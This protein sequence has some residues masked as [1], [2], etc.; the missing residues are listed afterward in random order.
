MFFSLSISYLLIWQINCLNS[1]QMATENSDKCSSS[2]FFISQVERLKAENPNIHTY[3]ILSLKYKE[4]VFSL[5][6]FCLLITLWPTGESS[7]YWFI[8]VDWTHAD[9]Q[10]ISPI[11]FNFWQS[12]VLQRLAYKKLLKIPILYTGF[13]VLTVCDCTAIPLE[14]NMWSPCSVGSGEARVLLPKHTKDLKF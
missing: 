1:L 10:H 7:I 3:N 2:Q 5:L 14:E 13:M 11:I 8:Y 12:N 9:N 4:L 6:Y